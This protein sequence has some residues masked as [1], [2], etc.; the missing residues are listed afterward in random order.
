MRK[1]IILLM[2]LLILPV[3]Y[4]FQPFSLVDYDSCAGWDESDGDFLKYNDLG[5]YN[6]ECQQDRIVMCDNRDT[7]HRDCC[8]GN[9]YCPDN[10]DKCTFSTKYICWNNDRIIKQ[11]CANGDTDSEIFKFCSG[12]CEDGTTQCKEIDNPNVQSAK[13]TAIKI[14]KTEADVD[15]WIEI[16]GSFY[17]PKSTYYLLE[18]GIEKISGAYSIYAIQENT[19]DPDE[20][21]YASDNKYIVQGTHTIRFYVRAPEPGTYKAHLA[22][23]ESCGGA[24]YQQLNSNELIKIT[25]DVDIPGTSGV[26][27]GTNLTNVFIFMLF[28]LIV[29]ILIVVLRRK[30]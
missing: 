17:A 26:P 2:A 11:T 10:S 7:C 24:V 1:L 6:C 8:P 5:W 29:L 16:Q 12:G 19:C 20:Q 22:Y 18:A 27:E 15:E 25:G 13:F 23:A 21:W 4:A 9:D 3:V 30:K 14:I 28:I